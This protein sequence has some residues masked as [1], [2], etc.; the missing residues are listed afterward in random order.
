MVEYDP[1]KLV[2]NWL[3]ERL[4][5]KNTMSKYSPKRLK[6]NADPKLAKMFQPD[7]GEYQIAKVKIL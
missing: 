3:L 6:W 7:E 1:R 4:T 2:A 5:N